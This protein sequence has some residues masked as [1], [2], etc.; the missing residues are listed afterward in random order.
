[1]VAEAKDLVLLEAVLDKDDLPDAVRTA[2]EDMQHKIDD[3]PL[4][5]KQRDWAKAVLNGDKFEPDA[6]EC[7]NLWSS[8]K[9]PRGREVPDPPM[10]RREN[11]PLKPPRRKPPPDADG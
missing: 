8:G 5:K 2:F 4:T 9:V 11:L 10:L 6:D 3:R 1:M 7:L